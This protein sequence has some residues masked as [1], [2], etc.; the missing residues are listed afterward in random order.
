MDAEAAAAVVAV[1]GGAAAAAAE[2]V[3]ACGSAVCVFADR[4]PYLARH[5]G[6]RNS[7]RPA[8]AWSWS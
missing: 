6:L 2:A 8:W 5:F 3:G 7:R 1:G 4:H